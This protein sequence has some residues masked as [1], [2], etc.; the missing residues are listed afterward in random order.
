MLAYF[1]LLATAFAAFAGAPIWTV[2]VGAA[3]LASVSLAGQRKLAERFALLGHT[4][5]LHMAM[6]QSVGHS[7]LAAGAGY[8]VGVLSRVAWIAL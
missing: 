4:H 7:L 3:V 8:A 6:W 1:A 5:V 2:L